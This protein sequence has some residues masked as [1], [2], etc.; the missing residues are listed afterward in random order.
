MLIKLKT[1]TVSAGSLAE[2]INTQLGFYK[3]AYGDAG[4]R[5]KHHQALHL[6]PMLARCPFM[7]S[8]FVNERRHRAVKKYTRDRRTLKSFDLGTIEEIACHQIW[9]LGKPLF[10]S[11]STSKPKGLML[12][13]LREVF[14]DYVG[15]APIMLAN[16][17]KV[18][19]GTANAGDV[20]SCMLSGEQAI[21]NL[22]L[23]AVVVETGAERSY[24]IISMWQMAADDPA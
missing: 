11:F 22:L 19:G 2:A 21:G 10:H 6:G 1:C 4:I 7:L 3:A 15:D 20:V 12:D 14:P 18:N 13:V 9:E 8:T 17:I 16:H 24:S 5:P 23:S